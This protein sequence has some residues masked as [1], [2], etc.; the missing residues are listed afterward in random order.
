M[1]REIQSQSALL[2]ILTQFFRLLLY[3]Y[4]TRFRQEYGLSISQVFRDEARSLLQEKNTAVLLQFFSRT[5]FDLVKNILVEHIEELFN[6]KLETESMSYHDAISDLSDNP[7]A[8]EQLYYDALKAGQQKAFQEAIDYNYNYSPKNLLLAGWFHRLHFAAEQA[9]RFIIEWRWIMPLAVL[10]GLLFWWFSDEERYINLVGGPTIPSSLLPATIMIAAPLTALFILIY[11]TLVGKKSWRLTAVTAAVPLL[12]GAY[13]YLIYPQTGVR[14]FQEQYLTIVV[15]HLPLLAWAS[16][17]LFFLARHRDATSRLR[18]LLKSVEVIVVGGIFAGV[19]VAFSGI[20]IALFDALDVTFSEALLRLIFGGGTGFI[21]V[22]APAIIYNPTVPPKE[23]SSSESIYRLASAVMQVLLPLTLLVLIIYIAF[24]PANFQAPFDSRD[25]LITYNVMLFAV[26]GLLVGATILR[27]V[28]SEPRRDIWLRRLIIG[29]AILTLVVSLYALSATIFRT[30]ND[31]LTP[32]RLTIIGWNVINIGLLVLLLLVQWRAN[33]AQWLEG[34]YR[35]FSIGTAVYA[36]WIAIVIFVLPW[37]FGV[38]QEK[39]E[40]LPTQIQE[41]VFSTPDPILLK[42][43]QSPH[44]YLLDD[45]Q[46]RWIEDIET[47]NTQGF[48]WRDINFVNCINLLNIPNG[49][50]IP[51]D[52]G[53]IPQPLE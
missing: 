28:D 33:A 51:E 43:Q 12:A 20:T 23:Q 47:F 45:G 1:Q 15:I 13:A 17:G 31:R 35:A 5:L 18:F 21:L 26:V 53:P 42:C 38:N 7:E 6:I 4:P 40:N 25:V 8:L 36:I 11:F 2:T 27:P 22:I 32:N 14:P 30:V 24:I 46:K 49:I 19:L 16:V 41:I 3:A 48:L 37:L 44:I 52:A 50:P 29:V 10:N 9:K 39:I 34:L